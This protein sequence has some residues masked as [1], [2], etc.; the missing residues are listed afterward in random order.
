MH[1]VIMKAEELNGKVL[2]SNR[3]TYWFLNL[4]KYWEISI[5]FLMQFKRGLKII[6]GF[7]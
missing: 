2:S 7:F 6:S 3:K 1:P 5:S 4:E